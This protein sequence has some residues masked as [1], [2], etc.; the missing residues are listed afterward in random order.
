MTVHCQPV[1]S[2]V[3]MVPAK[4]DYVNVKKGGQEMTVLSRSVLTTAMRMACATSTPMNVYATLDGQAKTVGCSSVQMIVSNMGRVRKGNATV[5]MVI[6][7]STVPTRLVLRTAM[8]MASVSQVFAFVNRVSLAK[9]VPP[10]SASMTV[11]AMAS[12][13]MVSVNV[14]L[15][16]KD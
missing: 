7:V 8:A 16:T 4:R 3:S 9:T 10:R 14:M 15:N 11:Q 12:V 1:P 13:L 5:T 6:R 2:S